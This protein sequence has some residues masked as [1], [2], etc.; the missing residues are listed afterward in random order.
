MDFLQV[1]VFAESAFSGNALA[2]FPDPGDLS[3]AQMQTI[4]REMN[5]SETT[6]VTSVSDAP[7]NTVT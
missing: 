4:A 7:Q 5:L 3:R 1:D 6:F 2:V